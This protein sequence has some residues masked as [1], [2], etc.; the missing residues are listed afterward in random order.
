[1]EKDTS[2]NE[3]RDGIEVVNVSPDVST[4]ALVILDVSTGTVT[5]ELSPAAYET[6]WNIAWHP[7]GEWL[8]VVSNGSDSP[9]PVD[10]SDY[11]F[12]TGHVD[13]DWHLYDIDVRDGQKKSRVGPRANEM[14]HDKMVS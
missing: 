7:S 11:S 12:E 14:G 2:S 4:D 5:F 10:P 9:D 1:M 6:Y 3:S 13:P 8:T